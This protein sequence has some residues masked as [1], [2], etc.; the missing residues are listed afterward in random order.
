[1]TN[2]SGENVVCV[3]N[4]YYTYF[5]CIYKPSVTHTSRTEARHLLKNG[6]KKKNV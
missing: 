2:S 1:M 5:E 4:L 3:Y 6:R